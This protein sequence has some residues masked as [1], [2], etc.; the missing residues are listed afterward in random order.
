GQLPGEML[1]LLHAVR[2]PEGCD[3]LAARLPR[4]IFDNL[5]R[6]AERKSRPLFEC[7]LLPEERAYLMAE[8]VE[9]VREIGWHGCLRQKGRFGSFCIPDKSLANAVWQ[10]RHGLFPRGEEHCKRLRE[11]RQALERHAR[12]EG[13]RLIDRKSVV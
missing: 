4:D 3:D 2:L 10:E 5:V 11:E 12:C 8:Y 9:K 7:A 13:C 1:Q 6:H